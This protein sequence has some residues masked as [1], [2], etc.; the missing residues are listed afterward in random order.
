M[1]IT[2]WGYVG[3]GWDGWISVYHFLENEAHALS[4]LKFT[5]ASCAQPSTK[6]GMA[7]AMPCFTM[8]MFKHADKRKSLNTSSLIIQQ[9]LL[10]TSNHQVFQNY[11][12]QSQLFLGDQHLQELKHPLAYHLLYISEMN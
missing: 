9:D 4:I 2:P 7:F 11:V 12:Q 6:Q 1:A 8:V 3:C 10:V 5:P